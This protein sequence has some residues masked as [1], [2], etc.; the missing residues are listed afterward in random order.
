MPVGFLRV[1]GDRIAMV[2][3]CTARFKVGRLLNIR[4]EL[5]EYQGLLRDVGRAMSAPSLMD[6]IWEKIEPLGLQAEKVRV[7]K[8]FSWPANHR[9]PARVPEH[10]RAVARGVGHV[11]CPLIGPDLAFGAAVWLDHDPGCGCSPFQCPCIRQVPP[12]VCCR[13]ISIYSGPLWAMAILLLLRTV[14]IIGWRVEVGR[15]VHGL[16]GLTRCTAA[17][18]D[19]V[20]YI[21]CLGSCP[22]LEEQ[23]SLDIVRT[24]HPGFAADSLDEASQSCLLVICSGEP[25]PQLQTGQWKRITMVT[26][27]MV[28]MLTS[29]YIIH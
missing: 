25:T 16:V 10:F 19:V 21:W 14:L 6:L 8:G 22:A 5:V 13:L 17:S 2:T 4:L 18:V 23:L 24:I 7:L 27:Q 9:G 3:I 20:A 28:S 26:V 12:V 15:G 29:S 1:Y 11:L